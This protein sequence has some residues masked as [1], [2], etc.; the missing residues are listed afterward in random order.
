[1]VAAELLTYLLSFIFSRWINFLI[2][3]IQKHKKFHTGPASEEGDETFL[4]LLSF[5]I[6]FSDT[7]IQNKSG[8]CI[9][10]FSHYLWWVFLVCH[11]NHEGHGI[12]SSSP[13]GGLSPSSLFYTVIHCACK[14]LLQ[15]TFDIDVFLISFYDSFTR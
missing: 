9:I 3:A 6:N 12:S 7:S 14:S 8:V 2:T 11:N 4:F 13:S 15:N 10:C 5:N 1:M